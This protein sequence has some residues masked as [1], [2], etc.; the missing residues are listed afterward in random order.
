MK[1]NHMKQLVEKIGLKKAILEYYKENNCVIGALPDD[2]Y[3][4]NSFF[5]TVDIYEQ[6]RKSC[7]EESSAYYSLGEFICTLP[8]NEAID[9]LIVLNAIKS[10]S[11]QCIKYKFDP[12]NAT[13]L[14]ADISKLT[15]RFAQT[16][17]A[18]RTSAESINALLCAVTGVKNGTVSPGLLV[19]LSASEKQDLILDIAESYLSVVKELKEKDSSFIYDPSIHALAKCMSY[20]AD[21]IFR[22]NE[23]G[24]IDDQ[25]AD[26]ALANECSF[27]LLLAAVF[28]SICGLSAV[29][30]I[31][32][33][34][35]LLLSFMTSSYW[36]IG[37]GAI[38]AALL[39]AHSNSVLY[40]TLRI[41]NYFKEC[42]CGKS[43][44]NRTISSAKDES[45]AIP[46][47]NEMS[48]LLKN[49]NV[50]QTAAF[51]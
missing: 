35:S 14:K 42:L 50:V 3:I 23:N 29:S 28:L 46:N 31:I 15:S 44:D 6:L 41:L 17:R 2:D 48:K 4:I 27:A 47:S 45:I 11:E 13:N 20:K 18:N 5:K 8:S 12:D 39:V 32:L 9:V 1:D 16:N 30:A 49:Q 25:S 33:Y 51:I 26:E 7:S 43:Q 21:D 38:L 24:S 40:K 22:R 10:L 36:L 34:G 37:G 19:P